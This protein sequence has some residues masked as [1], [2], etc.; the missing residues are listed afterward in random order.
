MWRRA[1]RR[2][3]ISAPKVSVRMDIPWYLRWGMIIPFVLL[4]L[5]L[6]WW[7][8]DN[9]LELAGF[10]RS[11]T[12]QE[13]SQLRVQVEKLTVDNAKLVS[14]VARYERQ[15]QIEQANNQEVSR[16]QKAASEE[17]ARLQEDLAFFENI[18]TATGKEEELR[19]DRAKLER[20]KMPGEFHLRVLLVQNGQRVKEFNGSYQVVVT[21]L[22]GG[23]HTTYLFPQDSLGNAQ[24]QLRF[25]YYH[26][27]EQSIQIPQDA[28]L[29]SV[30]VRIFEQ[31]SNVPKVRQ[32]VSM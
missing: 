12:Q 13:L 30:Q 32:N 1:K 18:T 15:L 25:K 2:F 23:Q 31:G 16:L 5:W 28:Q 11:E 4:A 21:A 19:L 6:A 24:F 9:G 22:K 29:E 27:I 17:N 14:E 26:R 3:G 8:Y 10:K 7:A 20:D